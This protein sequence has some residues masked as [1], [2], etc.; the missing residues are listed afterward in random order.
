MLNDV[1]DH[2][3]TKKTSLVLTLIWSIIM[4]IPTY[5]VVVFLW[6]F[7]LAIF[8]PGF[9]VYWFIFLNLWHYT[10]DKTVFW[11]KRRQKLVR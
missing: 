1:V 4:A 8:V 10:K 7:G 3:S 2:I 6:S 9:V 11:W 5:Y